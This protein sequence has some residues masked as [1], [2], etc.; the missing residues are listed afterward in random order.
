MI[1]VWSLSIAGVVLIV[2][3]LG[4]ISSTV[5]TNPHTILGKLVNS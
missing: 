1:L 2:L 4:D 5:M 3:E